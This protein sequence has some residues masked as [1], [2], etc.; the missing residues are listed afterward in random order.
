MLLQEVKWT[1]CWVYS[2]PLP[3][4]TATESPFY[5]CSGNGSH[6]LPDNNTEC[7]QRSVV[8]E[9]K[10]N[11]SLIKISSSSFIVP[12]CVESASLECR[13]W[14]CESWARPPED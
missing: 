8:W 2:G 4:M 10:K 7:A 5:V 11:L 1:S 6:T 9:K 14:C 3:K 13:V 12:D